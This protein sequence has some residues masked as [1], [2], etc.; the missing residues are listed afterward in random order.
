[1]TH[2][3]IDR[4]PGAEQSDDLVS[5][6]NSGNTAACIVYLSLTWLFTKNIDIK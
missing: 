1:M 6:L 4:L 5:R 2:S 3:C